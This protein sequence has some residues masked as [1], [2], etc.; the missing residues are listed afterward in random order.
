MVLLYIQVRCL[1]K[2][3]KRELKT[4][5]EN[6]NLLHSS[7]NIH[8]SDCSSSAGQGV[9]SALEDVCVLEQQ[10]AAA[11]DDLAAALPAFEQQRL[12]DAAALAK[13][14]QVGL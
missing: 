5:T 4:T 14:V 7:C 6:P 12:P 13:L 2:W 9:N 1:S 11:R 8:P 10:L 3:N